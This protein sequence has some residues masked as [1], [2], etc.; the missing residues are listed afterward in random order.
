MQ[1]MQVYRLCNNANM[2]ITQ[3]MQIVHIVQ[4]G[5]I[6]QIMPIVQNG[7]IVQIVKIMQIMLNMLIMQ[8]MPIM[9]FMQSRPNL[10]QFLQNFRQSRP[11][12][13]QTHQF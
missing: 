5:Q 3:I 4:N 13:S 1:S 9:H 11:Y 12:H 8:L 7:Q 10:R 2:H 6:V